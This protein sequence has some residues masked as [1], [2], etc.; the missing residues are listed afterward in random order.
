[1]GALR[2]WMGAL[3]HRVL[4]EGITDS[5]ENSKVLP[6]EGLFSE[7]F[8][9]EPNIHQGICECRCSHVCIGK[10][11]SGNSM[12]EEECGIRSMA[13][14][15]FFTLFPSP[16]AL[17]NQPPAFFQEGREGLLPACTHGRGDLMGSTTPWADF[18]QTP[19]PTRGFALTFLLEFSL[20]INTEQLQV[21]S[22]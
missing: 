20:L 21:S 14:R 12:G 7:R 18:Q 15:F 8:R 22:G 17:K 19:F 10:R 16:V 13:C 6:F 9:G 2:P 4:R 5:L 3:H 1:M 11:S